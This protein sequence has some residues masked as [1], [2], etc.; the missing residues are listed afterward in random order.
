M[1]MHRYF[2]HEKDRGFAILSPLG[3]QSQVTD[4]L[5]VEQFSLQAESSGHFKLGG[6]TWSLTC[7]RFYLTAS[8]QC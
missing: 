4:L 6:L 5:L 1:S 3:I 2:K 8:T 7:H